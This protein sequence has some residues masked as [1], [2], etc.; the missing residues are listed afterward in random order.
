[1]A[2]SAPL[3]GPNPRIQARQYRRAG[4]ELLR[5]AAV[6]DPAGDRRARAQHQL[7][8]DRDAALQSACEQVWRWLFREPWPA[9]VR[10]RW[11]R[12]SVDYYGWADVGGAA[13]GGELLVSWRLACHSEAPLVTVLHEMAHLRGYEHGREMDSA[14]ARWARRLGVD[15]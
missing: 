2:S 13:T 15:R 14:V 5:L 7:W 3:G 9:G 8:A 4:I 10:C 6:L 11:T 12:R 1:M